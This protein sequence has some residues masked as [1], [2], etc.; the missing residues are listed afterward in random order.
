MHQFDATQQEIMGEFHVW[1]HHGRELDA[2]RTKQAAEATL[3]R[4][5]RTGW[6]SDWMLDSSGEF[7]FLGVE[8]GHRVV[9]E[10]RNAVTGD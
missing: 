5:L 10:K 7:L 8:T 1:Y 6:S 4:A 9:T 3:H 2:F